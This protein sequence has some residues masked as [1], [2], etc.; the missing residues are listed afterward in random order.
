MILEKRSKS[1]NK[2][3]IVLVI[4]CFELNV[5]DKNKFKVLYLAKQENIMKLTKLNQ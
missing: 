2:T 5:V 1:L 3:K 4:Q